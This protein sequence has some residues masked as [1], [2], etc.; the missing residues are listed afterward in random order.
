MERN[1]TLEHDTLNVLAETRE[2]ICDIL[3]RL[4]VQERELE[5]VL[6]D[7]RLARAS[8]RERVLAGSIWG[9]RP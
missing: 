8:M 2:T 5:R 9:T 1:N 4:G 7:S 3:D 6:N